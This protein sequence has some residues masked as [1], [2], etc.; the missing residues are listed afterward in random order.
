VNAYCGAV[1][2]GNVMLDDAPT[3]RFED[4]DAFELAERLRRAAPSTRRIAPPRLLRTTV[5]LGEGTVLSGRYRIVH[6]MAA[7]WIAYDERLSRPVVIEPI[8]GRGAPAE[9]IRREAAR[10]ERLSDAVIFGGEA[11]AVRMTTVR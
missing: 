5:E 2:K 3:V 1:T 4:V 7:G 6:R 8:G 9:R 10:D 11:F